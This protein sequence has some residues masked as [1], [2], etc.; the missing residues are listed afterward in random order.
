MA[1][2]VDND[3]WKATEGNTKKTLLQLI[4]MVRLRPD[5]VWS[6]H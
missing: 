4:E 1:D 3:Y 5:G 2:D 6:D